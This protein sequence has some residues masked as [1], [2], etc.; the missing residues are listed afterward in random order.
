MWTVHAGGSGGATVSSRSAWLSNSE[1]NKQLVRTYTQVVFNDR[2]TS[3]AAEFLASEVTWHGSTGSP[4]AGQDQ[5]IA[6]IDEVV[7]AL[8]GLTVTEQKMTADGDTVVVRYVIEATHSRE[9]FGVSATGR[10]IRWE[11]TSVYRVTE[12]KIVNAVTF[13]NLASVLRSASGPPGPARVPG[14]PSRSGVP[15]Q[16]HRSP[17]AAAHTRE[18]GDVTAW[19]QEDSGW[20]LAISLI[21]GWRMTGGGH[22]RDAVA[23]R[24][25]QAAAEGGPAAGQ[26]VLGL[27]ALGTMFLELY[28]DCT[29]KSVDTVLQDASAVRWENGTSG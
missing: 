1:R 21:D 27:T 20:H 29:G 2:R 4:I 23:L 17:P 12:G 5:V 9:L 7:G 8:D 13:G 26:A 6:L 18:G 14:T 19:S 28:A 24:L 11:P 3:R 15:A 22:N 25:A 16:R 10:R